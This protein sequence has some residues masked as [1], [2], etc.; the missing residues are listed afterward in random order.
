MEVE[1]RMSASV[2]RKLSEK[3][4][5]R[6]ERKLQSPAALVVEEEARR[7]LQSPAALVVEE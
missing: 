2:L 3:R 5:V 1:V 6:R 7:K 4:N